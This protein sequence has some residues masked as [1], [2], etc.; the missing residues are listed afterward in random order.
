MVFKDVEWEESLREEDGA[1]EEHD[2][3]LAW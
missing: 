2:G 1:G 3:D